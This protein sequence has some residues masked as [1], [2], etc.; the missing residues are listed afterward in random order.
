[1]DRTDITS[2]ELA[3]LLSASSG[4]QVKVDQL[5]RTTTFD[6]LGVESLALLGVITSIERSRAIALPTE[7]QEIESVQEFL[8]LLNESLRKEA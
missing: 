1:M 2:Q 8:N 4:I 5:N 3:E 6:D 7:A